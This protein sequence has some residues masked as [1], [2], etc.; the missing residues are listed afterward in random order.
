[1][2]PDPVKTSLPD[3]VHVYDIG[4]SFG[5]RLRQLFD[6]DVGA[7]LVRRAQIRFSDVTAISVPLLELRDALDRAAC[8]AIAPVVDGTLAPLEA[9]EKAFF[10]IGELLIGK[11]EARL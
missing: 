4:M 10:V 2:L 5:L 11:R 9:E 6:T 3:A 8:P 1:K 7:D